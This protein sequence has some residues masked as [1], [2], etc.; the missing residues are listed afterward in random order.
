MTMGF[1]IHARDGQRGAVSGCARLLSQPIH[2]T[3]LDPHVPDIAIARQAEA[4]MDM[5]A[6]ALQTG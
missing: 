1:S 5:G 4:P 6:P 3:V 2:V